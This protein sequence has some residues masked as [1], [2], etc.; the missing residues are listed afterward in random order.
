MVLIAKPTQ[1]PRHFEQPRVTTWL[2]LMGAY[3]ALR[4]LLAS[5]LSAP[6]SLILLAVVTTSFCSFAFVRI[7]KLLPAL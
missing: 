6:P 5:C 7:D 1:R 3:D 4:S 2:L